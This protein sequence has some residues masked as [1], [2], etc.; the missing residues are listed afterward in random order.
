MFKSI[1][2]SRLILVTLMMQRVSVTLLADEMSE[3][4]W[5]HRHLKCI[6]KIYIDC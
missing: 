6:F 1:L 2:L 4:A 3:C 5:K